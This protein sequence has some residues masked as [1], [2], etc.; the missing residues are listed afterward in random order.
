MELKQLKFTTTPPYG[1]F[2][3]PSDTIK[4]VIDINTDDVEFIKDEVKGSGAYIHAEAQDLAKFDIPLFFD[5]NM[6][7]LDEPVDEQ[8]ILMVLPDGEYPMKSELQENAYGDTN[9]YYLTFK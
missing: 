7:Q 8:D 4:P 1:M 5:G 9:K 6:A 2:G 3:G